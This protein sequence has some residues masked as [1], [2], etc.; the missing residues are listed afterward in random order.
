[1]K[2]RL[3]HKSLTVALLAI[4]STCCFAQEH[5][6]YKA[7]LGEVKQS[8]FYKILLPPKVIGRCQN[9]VADLRILDEQNHQVAYM[10]K[11]DAAQFSESSFVEFPI[12]KKEKEKD[13]IGRAHV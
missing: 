10:V 6:A 2:K 9:D 7:R 3:L 12:I 13:K 4:V 1:M 11:Q 5:F 8:A